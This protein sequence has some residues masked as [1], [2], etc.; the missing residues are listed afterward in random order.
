MVDIT[1]PP[2][3][4][5]EVGDTG[6][7]QDQGRRVGP[8]RQRLEAAPLAEISGQTLVILLRWLEERDVGVEPQVEEGAD[9][10]ELR[11]LASAQP[12]VLPDQLGPA[13]PDVHPYQLDVLVELRLGRLLRDRRWYM[14]NAPSR[15]PSRCSSTSAATPTG[16]PSPTTGS[17]PWTP[18]R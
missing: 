7:N 3:E 9:R 13:L 8:S 16:S 4:L 10:P 2:A 15:G 6:Q 14:R 1:D 11:G 12:H 5:Q 17:S 18:G